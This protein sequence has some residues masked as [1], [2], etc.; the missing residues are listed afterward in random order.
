MIHDFLEAARGIGRRP[1][2]AA[3][4]I[5]PLALGIGAVST[6]FSAVYGVLL[7]PPPYAEPDRLM[8]V[9]ERRPRLPISDEVAAFSTD[10]FRAW[11]DANTVFDGMVMYGDFP[12]AYRGLADAPGD[13]R[14]LSVERASVSVFEVLG[15]SPMLGRGFRPEEATPGRDNVAV[16]GHAF[17][18]REFGGDESVIGRSL[19]FD[20]RSFEVVG[21]M[22][23]DFGFPIPTT[24]VY[25]PYAE[26]PAADLAPGQVRLELVQVVARLG[27]GVSPEQAEAEAGA[28]IARLSEASATQ[29][30]L[31][32]GVSV[33][34]D[35]FSERATRR[36]RGP[37]IA[38]FGVTLFVLLIAC[39]NVANLLLTRAAWRERE[40]A[41]RS[42]L[43]ADRGQLARGLLAE[44]L[45]F[46][47]AAG[48]IAVLVSLQGAALVRSLTVLGLPQLQNARVD[49]EVV[50]FTFLAA[51]IAALLSGAVPA[52]RAS[53]R[54]PATV[55]GASGRGDA[56]AL[57][58]A[59]RGFARRGLFASAQLA[60]SLPLL[61]GAGLFTRSFLELAAAPPGYE[62][63]NTVT[64]QIQLPEGRYD[65]AE[66]RAGV[67]D[68]LRESLA[69]VPGVE[70]AGHVN[71][72][73]LSGERSVIGFQRIGQAP[74]TD[75]NQVPRA[76]LR[77]VSPGLF[78]AMG[79]PLVEG[80]VFEESDRTGP[81]VLVVNEALVDR[82]LADPPVGLELAGLG[83]IVGV[84][85][86]THEEGVDT[87]VEPILY[88]LDGTGPASGLGPGTVNFVL[89]HA[90]GTEVASAAAA[91]VR[92]VDSELRAIGMTSLGERIRESVAQPRLYALLL[93]GF[94]AA[95]MLLAL[96]GVFGV[97]GFQTNARL[98]AYGIRMAFGATPARIRRRIVGDALRIAAV[99]LLPGLL[100]A[101][102]LTRVLGSGLSPF[103]FGVTPLDPLVV[104]LATLSLLAAAGVAALGPAGRAARL[105]VAAA[106]RT[107]APAGG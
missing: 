28:L 89:R 1:G 83:Q 96:W 54:D 10:H 44:S 7:A 62:P 88:L 20:D 58:G 97:V 68:R 9:W 87:P 4:V 31:N 14:L 15:V 6:V 3:L 104:A 25:V 72:L 102:F 94:A 56:A 106:F 13:P 35:S 46:A 40:L 100:L 11:R 38:L 24:E 12:A 33:H 45:V 107:E 19:R 29:A 105:D 21:I 48:G 5:L 95:A 75:P 42:A 18:T 55:L 99:G 76:M 77:Q 98:P 53:R 16:L 39:G 79:I 37:L 86:S 103:L 84:V 80:R 51:G 17:W 32:E 49:W 36:V 52:F 67:L 47:G 74:V 8:Q 101:W 34:L 73:P 70:T 50:A 27:D 69:A 81:P 2:F 63:A 64:F 92:E 57:S 61:V 26:E 23:A 90:P 66:A 71:T 93:G 30:M 43:G 41:V 59:G 65:G 22:P 78:R 82:Y 60:L 85:G 91:R